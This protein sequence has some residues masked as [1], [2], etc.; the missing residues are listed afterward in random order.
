MNVGTVFKRG[1]LKRL[2]R[3]R[4]ID[5]LGHFVYYLRFLPNR[6]HSSA[7]CEAEWK[8]SSNVIFEYP[9]CE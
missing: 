9:N 4:G 2:F 5:A 6:V 8:R 1:I 3:F 7:M